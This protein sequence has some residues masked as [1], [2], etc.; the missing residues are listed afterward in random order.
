VV[1][2]IIYL[3]YAD[4]PTRDPLAIEWVPDDTATAKQAVADVLGSEPSD[5]PVEVG[6][7]DA[8]AIRGRYADLTSS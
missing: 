1:G 5:Y 2:V 4:R 3:R 8:K 7:A 6:D